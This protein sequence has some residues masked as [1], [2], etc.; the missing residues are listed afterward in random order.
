MTRS[1][2]P[3]GDDTQKNDESAEARWLWCGQ[4]R[5][6][7]FRTNKSAL[8]W[9]STQEIGLTRIALPVEPKAIWFR[10]E[11]FK[12]PKTAILDRLHL[13]DGANIDIVFSNLQ[14]IIEPDEGTP[15]P[16]TVKL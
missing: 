13:R 3:I 8:D 15:P 9:A 14:K 6:G 10:F 16:V 7:G 1:K 4:Y 2:L 11:P 5:S 12:P